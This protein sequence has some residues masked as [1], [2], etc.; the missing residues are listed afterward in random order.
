M[1]GVVMQHKGRILQHMKLSCLSVQQ[2][3]ST[4]AKRYLAI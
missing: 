3:S 2:I 4:A 1:V